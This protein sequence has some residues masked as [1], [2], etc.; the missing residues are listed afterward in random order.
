M[1]QVRVDN[2]QDLY[3]VVRQTYDTDGPLLAGPVQL[4]A[5][6]GSTTQAYG[7]FFGGTTAGKDDQ[8][9]GPLE[10]IATAVGNLGP[11]ARQ[12]EAIIR[13]EATLGQTVI[14]AGHSLG[15]GVAERVAIEL[16]KDENGDGK[17]D[18]NV[19]LVTY[20]SPVWT[21][22]AI[23]DS[24][25]TDFVAQGDPV[26]YLGIY[27]ARSQNTITPE[28]GRALRAPFGS[29][30][31]HGSYQDDVF[32]QYEPF[33]NDT[34]ISSITYDSSQMLNWE[35]RGI[36]SYIEGTAPVTDEGI[37]LAQS[38][39]AQA[40]TSQLATATTPEQQDALI[41]QARGV[42]DSAMGIRQE[43]IQTAE[44]SDATSTRDLSETSGPRDPARDLA[45]QSQP[46]MSQGI[47]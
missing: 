3:N 47:G 9:T 6:D 46:A 32:A 1:S 13:Q 12:A 11:Y 20:G 31:A 10:N 36:G 43:A 17:P 18:Y 23:P 42:L 7:A 29:D 25:R 28:D 24:Q 5:N 2:A 16:Q 37:M 26:P 22:G 38:A 21:N 35:I 34:N 19:Q 14:L 33:G 27:T 4:N 41:A 15:G 44:F 39:R 45:A 40:L 8:A 30:G